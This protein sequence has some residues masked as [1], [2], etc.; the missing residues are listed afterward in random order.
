MMLSPWFPPRYVWAAIEGVAGLDITTD[1]P[2]LTPR[3]A[4]A[5]SWYGVRDLPFRG[6]KLTWFAVQAPDLRVYSSAPFAHAAAETYTEDISHLL[7]LSGASVIALA[8]RRPGSFAVMVG[9]TNEHSVV[10][11]LRIADANLDGMHA[12][13][14]YN[15]LRNAWLDKEALSADRL[16]SGIPLEI[17]RKGFCIIEFSAIVPERA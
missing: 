12:M 16:R 13:R 11:S 4:P 6:R 9:N 15:S 8:L 7:R 1:P 5:W 2:G 3:M 17:A 10:A 14:V